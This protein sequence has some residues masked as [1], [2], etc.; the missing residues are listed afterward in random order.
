MYLTNAVYN[1]DC[2]AKLTTVHADAKKPQKQLVAV[3]YTK[4]YLQKIM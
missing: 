1:Y 2:T 3:V 4:V